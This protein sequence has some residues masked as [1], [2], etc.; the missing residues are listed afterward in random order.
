MAEHTHHVPNLQHLGE[1]FVVFG[2]KPL[3]AIALEKTMSV[4]DDR[5]GMTATGHSETRASENNE[6]VHTVDTSAGVVFDTQVN[7]LLDTETEA[8]FQQ[9][10][11]K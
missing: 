7:V 1:V 9:V 8:T 5:L 2:L 6:E 11:R 10:K 3:D 4:A